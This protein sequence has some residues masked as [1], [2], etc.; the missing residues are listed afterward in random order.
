MRTTPCPIKKESASVARSST[1][2]PLSIEF[3]IYEKSIQYL[4]LSFFSTVQSKGTY[5]IFPFQE[6]FWVRRDCY[7]RGSAINFEGFCQFF[8]IFSENF[9]ILETFQVRYQSLSTVSQ[10]QKKFWDIFEY[11]LLVFVADISKETAQNCHHL[12]YI[13][14]GSCKESI[15]V[16]SPS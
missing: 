11:S 4:A 6:T 9:R 15:S 1:E 2:K 12:W 14:V 13:Y 8:L 7:E 5:F 16:I 10:W 3:R